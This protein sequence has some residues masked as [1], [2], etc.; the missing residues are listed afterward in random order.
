MLQGKKAIPSYWQCAKSTMHLSILTPLWRTVDGLGGA[1]DSA[2]NRLCV[3]QFWPPLFCR[4]VEFLKIFISENRAILQLTT[5]GSLQLWI[6]SVPFHFTTT[7]VDSST[8]YQSSKEYS[9]A[10]GQTFEICNS[11]RV[12]T[13]TRAPHGLI[14][15][16]S[17]TLEKATKGGKN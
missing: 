6:D 9:S 13:Q 3:F 15:F 8:P 5:V 2:Q 17:W 11:W 7:P 12:V 16:F 14:L 1:V 4:T 10:N